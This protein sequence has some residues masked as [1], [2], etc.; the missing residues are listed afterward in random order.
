LL[1]WRCSLER[2][3]ARFGNVED[4]SVFGSWYVAMISFRQFSL[5]SP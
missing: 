5:F 3:Y 2:Y 4:G 1:F